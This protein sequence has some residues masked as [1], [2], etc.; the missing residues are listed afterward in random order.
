M[1]EIQGYDFRLFKDIFP[2]YQSF[3]T[4]YSNTPFHLLYGQMPDIVTFTII[5]NEYCVSH[6]SYSDEVFKNKF[7]NDLYTYFEDFEQESAAIRDLMKLTSEEVIKAGSTVLNIA[8]IPEQVNST[9]AETVSFVSQ[10][11]KTN[12]FRS[13]LEAKR[14]IIRNKR[15]LSVRRFLGRFRHLFMK[16]ISPDYIRVYVEEEHE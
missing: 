15:E 7:A 11:Q 8:D 9:D 16:I 6:V 1:T 4:W 12:M 5:Y 3:S 2:D 13:E 10:Q 14:E